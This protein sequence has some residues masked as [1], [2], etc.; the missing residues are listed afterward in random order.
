MM[1]ASLKSRGYREEVTAQT[2]LK[3]LKGTIF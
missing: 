3:K 1:G 2:E